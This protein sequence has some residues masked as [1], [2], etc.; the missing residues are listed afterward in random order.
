L[1]QPREPPVRAFDCTAKRARYALGARRKP[2][3]AGAPPDFG[4]V[5]ARPSWWGRGH[6]RVLLECGHS[7]EQHFAR[8]DPVGPGLER[9]PSRFR[10]PLFCD[11]SFT[12]LGTRFWPLDRA[13]PEAH[14]SKY[15]AQRSW[16]QLLWPGARPLAQRAGFRANSLG[17]DTPGLR[18]ADNARIQQACERLLRS[19]AR[20]GSKIRSRLAGDRLS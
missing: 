6:C 8:L 11:S 17:A 12:P 5:A 13:S 3:A 14:K 4:D 16:P 9:D 7:S 1:R 2:H 15:S 18:R 20:P 19:S 10:R